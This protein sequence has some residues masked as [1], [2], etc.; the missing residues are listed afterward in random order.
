M[1]E[2]MWI[3]KEDAWDWTE[4]EGQTM[5]ILREMY[6]LFGY[7]KLQGFTISLKDYHQLLE[8]DYFTQ[9]ILLVRSRNI[10]I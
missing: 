7:H 5:G 8:K 3:L 9:N 4:E 10:C 6:W 2:S 1:D